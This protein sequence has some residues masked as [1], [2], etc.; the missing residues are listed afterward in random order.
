MSGLSHTPP[1]PLA[2]LPSPSPSLPPY[3]GLA[4][5]FR[6]EGFCEGCVHEVFGNLARLSPPLTPTHQPTLLLGGA[7]HVPLD[8][9]YREGGRW[10]RGGGK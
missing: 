10:R 8:D 6:V 4:L 2:I 5:Q 9:T 1:L 7:G 3:S